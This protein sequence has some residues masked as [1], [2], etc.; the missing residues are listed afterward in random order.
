MI[1]DPPEDVTYDTLL[2]GRVGLFQPARGFRSSLDPVLLAGFVG[3][4][5][6]RFVDIGCGTGALSFLLLA[7]DPQ[8]TGVGIEIQ[9][10]LAALAQRGAERNGFGARYEV[11][12]ADVRVLGEGARG[13]FDLV[14]TNPPYQP[15][16]SGFLPP[17]R[18]RSIA[19]HEVALTLSAWLDATCALM[20]E[21][22]RLCV[23]FPAERRGEL[24][25]G[26]RA[27]GLVATRLRLVLPQAG[28]PPRRVMVEARREG[29]FVEEP[30]LVVHEGRGFTAEVRRMLG[31]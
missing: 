3:G 29:M 31:E 23:I 16:G 19:H 13:T 28:A 8:A 17:D 11:R 24:E 9:P 25:S 5:Y 20:G 6:R 12:A 1:A 21:G 2:R 10:R 22:G 14:A 4:G 18:E 15:L 7:Q 30:P 27:R 26:L